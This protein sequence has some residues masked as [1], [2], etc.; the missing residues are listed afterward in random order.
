MFT[1]IGLGGSASKIVKKFDRKEYE[2][3]LTAC[4]NFDES[5]I[6][7]KCIPYKNLY[8]SEFNEDPEN[9]DYVI[10]SIKD[11][12]IKSIH[13]QYVI[14]VSCVGSRISG[15]LAYLV[16]LLE[17]IGK[18]VHVVIQSPSKFEGERR[19]KNYDYVLTDLKVVTNKFVYLDSKEL[20]KK[21][22]KGTLITEWFQLLDE[23]LSKM[24]RI[25][26]RKILYK[27]DYEKRIKYF[28][29]QKMIEK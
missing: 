26:I 10:D 7:C 3:I 8:F 12:I 2:I 9:G 17:E 25:E 28:E 24:I 20:Y 5:F 14:I 29:E 4:D 15:G 23:E 18:D 1:I 21:A 22:H 6:G 16:M 27:E 13:N 11:E 19:Q